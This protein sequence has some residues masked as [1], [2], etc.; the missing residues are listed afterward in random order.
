MNLR[1]F[2]EK[3]SDADLLRAMTR[4]PETTDD[5]FFRYFAPVRGLRPLR[6]ERCFTENAPKPR[7]STRSL[8]AMMAMIPPRMASTMFSISR[9][10][11]ADSGHKFSERVRI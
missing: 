4:F 6:P 11:D 8:R 2:L 3:H 1:T 5:L 7:N 10:Y 9:W